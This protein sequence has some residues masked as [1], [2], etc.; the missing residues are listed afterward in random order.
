MATFI[1]FR[2]RGLGAAKLVDVLVLSNEAT[3]PIS[4]AIAGAGVPQRRL[5]LARPIIVGSFVLLAG[6]KTPNG[7]STGGQNSREP[8]GGASESDA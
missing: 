2:P 7:A 3:S 8:R 6:P 5:G 1:T 4:D